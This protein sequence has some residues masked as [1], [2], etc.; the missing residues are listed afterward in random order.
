MRVLVSPS[1]VFGVLSW[2]LPR[3]LRVRSHE[4]MLPVVEEHVSLAGMPCVCA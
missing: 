4:G 1:D 2:L 3:H